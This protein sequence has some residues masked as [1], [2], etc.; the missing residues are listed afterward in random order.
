MNPGQEQQIKEIFAKH[1]SEA[2]DEIAETEIVD[3]WWTEGLHVRLADQTTQTIQ[4]MSETLD[5]ERANS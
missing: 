2:I 3:V 1:L 4:A 5:I